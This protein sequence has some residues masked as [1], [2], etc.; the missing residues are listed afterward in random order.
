MKIEKTVYFE[1]PGS[2]NTDKT[3]EVAKDRAVTLDIKNIVV[4][5]TSG[6]T[7]LKA[8]KVFKDFN[9][10]VV[11]GHTGSSKPGYQVMDPQIEK[12]ITKQAKLVTVTG[13]L[14]GVERS[15]RMKFGTIGILELMA[16]VLRRFG[17]GVKV[18]IEIS[19]MAADAGVIPINSDVLAIGG[20][21]SGADTVIILKP[22]HSNNFFDLFVKETIAKPREDTT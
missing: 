13:S 6:E 22:A 20:T 12:E 16:H 3:L 7:G 15:I 19:V 5:S 18:A 17:N 4:A 1:T 2:Q 21:H 10:V 14:S 8:C 11:R 9:L